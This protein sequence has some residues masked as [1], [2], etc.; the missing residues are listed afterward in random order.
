VKQ[1]GLAWIMYTSDY[2]DSVCWRDVLPPAED[3]MYTF[4][5]KLNPYTKN[6]QLWICPSQNPKAVNAWPGAVSNYGFNDWYMQYS[7]ASWGGWGAINE[8]RLWIKGTMILADIESPA[9]TVVMCD[10][11]P[12]YGPSRGAW[13]AYWH[14]NPRPTAGNP[15]M[16]PKH[17]DGVNVLL[18]DGHAKWYRP[19]ALSKTING[20][21]NYYWKVNKVPGGLS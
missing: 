9:E 11:N 6:N 17:N 14:M 21:N 12:N 8:Y 5:A 4:P 15:M 18:A 3:Y 2:D 19:E 13:W 1:I 10:C 20:V 7:M 16:P